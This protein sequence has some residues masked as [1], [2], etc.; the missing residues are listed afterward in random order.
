M[1]NTLIGLLFGIGLGAFIYA[2]MIRQSGGNTKMSLITA[3]LVGA[4]GFFV[5]FTL[6]ATFLSDN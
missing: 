4:V 1:S 6:F 5:V 3:V 2:K